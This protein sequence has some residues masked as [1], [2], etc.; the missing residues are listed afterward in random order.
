M[1]SGQYLKFDRGTWQC[2][3]FD[4]ASLPFLKFD[5]RRHDIP[6]KALNGYNEATRGPCH[7]L[8]VGAAM[9]CSEVANLTHPPV[10]PGLGMPPY[11]ND[12]KII[13]F[14]DA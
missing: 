13:Y 2:L 7:T 14:E 3:R 10:T 5:M 1:T 4:W 8:S 12:V 6:S 11:S 9:T